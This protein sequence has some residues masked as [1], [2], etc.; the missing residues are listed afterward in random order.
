MGAGAAAGAQAGARIGQWMPPP[1]LQKV[2]LP[3]GMA[4]LRRAASAAALPAGC[5][6]HLTAAKQTGDTLCREAQQP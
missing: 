1:E 5:W 3:W 6:Q 4:A 2:R